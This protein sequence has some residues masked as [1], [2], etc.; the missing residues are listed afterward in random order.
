M[1]AKSRLQKV[2]STILEHDETVVVQT[3]MQ[4]K[5]LKT[6]DEAKRTLARTAG[7]LALGIAT[8]GSFTVVTSTAPSWLVVTS[9]RVFVLSRPDFA[10]PE[11]LM[12]VPL[13]EV[14]AS[15]KQRI[16]AEV[17]IG[18]RSD[19]EP[20]LRMN[21]GWRPGTARR[22]VAAVEGVPVG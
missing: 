4:V 19:G 7:S 5:K 14:T 10:D 12:Q 20:L 17:S 13:A 21:L 22:V 9:R 8:A 6:R 2:L 18:M 11:L 1:S 16:L 15:R 3:G